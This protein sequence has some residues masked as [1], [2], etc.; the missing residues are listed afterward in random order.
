MHASAPGRRRDVGLRVKRRKNQDL[1]IKSQRLLEGW[2]VEAALSAG[3]ETVVVGPAYVLADG[4]SAR[5]AFYRDEESRLCVGYAVDEGGWQVEE[6]DRFSARS[7]G[8]Y[9][10]RLKRIGTREAMR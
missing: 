5:L 2:A 3:A 7:L 1:S 8:Y 4:R 10:R 6:G 9:Q